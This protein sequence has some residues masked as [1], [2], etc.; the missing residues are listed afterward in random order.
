MN[1][2]KYLYKLSSNEKKHPIAKKVIYLF[3]K[4]FNLY[5]LETTIKIY[6]F[7]FNFTI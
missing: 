5:N 6:F 7:R 3:I 4:K 2:G 1:S